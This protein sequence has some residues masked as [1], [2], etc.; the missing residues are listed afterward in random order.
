MATPEPG[1]EPDTELATT[2]PKNTKY[3]M[4][5]YAHAD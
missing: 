2:K 5:H 3:G 4:I 1:A